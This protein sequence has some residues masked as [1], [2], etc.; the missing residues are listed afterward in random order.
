MSL[1]YVD[2]ALMFTIMGYFGSFEIKICI[3]VLLGICTLTL[4]F[5]RSRRSKRFR[6]HS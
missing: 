3:F 1:M 2:L 5:L 6:N 4:L